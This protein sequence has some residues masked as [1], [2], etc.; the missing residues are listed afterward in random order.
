MTIM[1]SFCHLDAIYTHS[2]LPLIDTI[3]ST[4][5]PFA[6]SVVM[7]CNVVRD[8]IETSGGHLVLGQVTSSWTTLSPLSLNLISGGGVCAAGAATDARV[9]APPPAEGDA[10]AGLA[11]PGAN[12]GV[13]E[14][15]NGSSMCRAPRAWVVDGVR[16]RASWNLEHIVSM[17]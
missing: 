12:Q 10:R 16:G 2:L 14:S 7:V 4:Y 6:S 15:Y 8:S 13:R 11:E 9:R 1:H 3:K 5:S 17:A